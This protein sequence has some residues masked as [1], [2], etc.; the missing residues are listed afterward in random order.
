MADVA[1]ESEPRLATLLEQVARGEDSL[2]TRDGAVA[3]RLSSGDAL[4][5]D[6]EASAVMAES[7]RRRALRRVSDEDWADIARRGR[8]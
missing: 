3:A 5:P 7:R 1:M 8:D 4:A 6:A 2:L